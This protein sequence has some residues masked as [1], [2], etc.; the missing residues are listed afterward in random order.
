MNGC[1]RH[2]FSCSF[3]RFYLKG[4]TAR[5]VGGTFSSLCCFPSPM[6]TADAGK[7]QFM[8]ALLQLWSPITSGEVW[9]CFLCGH[10]AACENNCSSRDRCTG[11]GWTIW[12]KQSCIFSILDAQMGADFQQFESRDKFVDVHF[13]YGLGRILCICPCRKHTQILSR[14]ERLTVVPVPDEA[15][16]LICASFF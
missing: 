6:W 9:P 13:Q 1:Y 14:Q 10:S 11:V 16:Q 12:W 2:L 3:S 8:S 4:F 15:A 7:P 5:F